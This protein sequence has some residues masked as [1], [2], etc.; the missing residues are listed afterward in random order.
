MN[1]LLD[2]LYEVFRIATFQ[3]GSRSRH[4]GFPARGEFEIG[5][6]RMPGRERSGP[7]ARPRRQRREPMR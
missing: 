1:E 3:P 4:G 2:T 5:R 6:H 7:T